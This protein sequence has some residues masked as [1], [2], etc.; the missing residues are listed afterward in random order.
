MY[1]Y[2]DCFGTEERINFPYSFRVRF[3]AGRLPR[4]SGEGR[5]LP[6]EVCFRC[7]LRC[8]ACIAGP[9][10][11]TTASDGGPETAPLERWRRGMRGRG[12]TMMRVWISGAAA[13]AAA[14]A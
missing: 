5:C 7:D 9:R 12:G 6:G 11:R 14:L 2:Y 13:L 3:H 8:Q 4:P 10:P 1:V